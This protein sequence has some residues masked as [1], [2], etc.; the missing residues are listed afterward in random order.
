M[1]LLYSYGSNYSKFIIYYSGLSKSNAFEA[2][3]KDSHG[4]E[5]FIQVHNLSK[6]F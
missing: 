2:A 1:V 6:G 5:N 4:C 3:R